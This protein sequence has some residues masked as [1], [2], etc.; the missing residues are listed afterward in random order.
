MYIGKCY[1]QGARDSPKEVGDSQKVF[2]VK[3]GRK[4]NKWDELPTGNN[5]SLPAHRYL[6]EN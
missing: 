5:N 2:Q 3:M 4:D 6:N 1:K